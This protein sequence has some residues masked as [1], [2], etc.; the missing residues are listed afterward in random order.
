MVLQMENYCFKIFVTSILCLVLSP[1]GKKNAT[2]Y[3]DSYTSLAT[4][5]I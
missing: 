1:R 3:E 2:Q 4:K 5:E